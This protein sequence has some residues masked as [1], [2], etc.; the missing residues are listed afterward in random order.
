MLDKQKDNCLSIYLKCTENQHYASSLKPEDFPIS[1][2]HTG[3]APS[4]A[5]GKQQEGLSS[6]DVFMGK[7]ENF[8]M[9]LEKCVWSRN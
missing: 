8:K 9:V 1:E 5:P 6:I 2:M 4:T 7:N 3:K